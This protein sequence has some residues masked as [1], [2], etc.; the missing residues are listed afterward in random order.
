M[1]TETRCARVCAHELR[2]PRAVPTV[3]VVFI[4]F[5]FV[6]F[7]YYYSFFSFNTVRSAAAA[8]AKKKNIKNTTR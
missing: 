8:A 5:R 2:T 1:Y 6:I 3:C 7:Y 4:R